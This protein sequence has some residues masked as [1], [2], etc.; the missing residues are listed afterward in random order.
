MRLRPDIVDA[1]DVRAGGQGSVRHRDAVFREGERGARI[2]TGRSVGS[3]PVTSK[4]IGGTGEPG[5]SPQAIHSPGT[6]IEHDLGRLARDR[7]DSSGERGLKDK[8]WGGP[9]SSAAGLASMPAIGEAR[10]EPWFSHESPPENRPPSCLRRPHERNG[11][12]LYLILG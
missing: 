5:S 2:G 9:D 1:N 6:E 7:T 8:R 12:S 11:S 10:R 4:I 3:S